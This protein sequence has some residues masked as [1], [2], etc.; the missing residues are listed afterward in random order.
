MEVSS[1]PVGGAARR[2]SQHHSVCLYLRWGETQ[3]GVSMGTVA[4]PTGGGNS[5]P[6]AVVR[7]AWVRALV[8]R[9]PCSQHS[10]LVR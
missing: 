9:V 8:M 3:G 5:H 10:I 7:G 1:P 6:Y 4:G 2:G